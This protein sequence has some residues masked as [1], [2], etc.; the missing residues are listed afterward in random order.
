MGGQSNYTWAEN[1][2]N[3]LYNQRIPQAFGVTIRQKRDQLMVSEASFYV[4]IFIILQIVLVTQFNFYFLTEK[5]KCFII[6]HPSLA[7]EQVII[8]AL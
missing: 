5:Q 6:N 2:I 8:M 3:L 1:K 4:R 7:K